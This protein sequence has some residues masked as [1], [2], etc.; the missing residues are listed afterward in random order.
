MTDP[1]KSRVKIPRREPGEIA[2]ANPAPGD[3]ETQLRKA[4][5]LSMRRYGRAYRDLAKH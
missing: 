1:R 5:E 4:R 2:R 3:P